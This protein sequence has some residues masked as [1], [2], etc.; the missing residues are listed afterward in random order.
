M[1]SWCLSVYR[2]QP[3][4]LSIILDCLWFPWYPICQHLS[5]CKPTHATA[6]LSWL[7]GIASW[8]F[9]SSLIEILIRIIFI[10]F[11]KFLLCYVFTPPLKVLIPVVSPRIIFILFFFFSPTWF[12]WLLSLSAPSSRIHS[13]PFSLTMEIH[14]YPLDHEVHLISFGMWTIAWLSFTWWL[15]SNYKWI[16]IIICF[17]WSM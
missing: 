11:R 4:L 1:G 15:I 7:Q 12:L 16:H 14:V 17:S 8:E 13:I 5:Q 10:D 2:K 3:R 9:I 6:S